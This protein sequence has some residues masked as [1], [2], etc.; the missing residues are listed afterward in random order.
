VQASFDSCRRALAD[1]APVPG[2]RATLEHRRRPARTERQQRSVA[3]ACLF[4]EKVI[5]AE[6]SYSTYVTKNFSPRAYL[7]GARHF[8]HDIEGRLATLYT[9]VDH[10]PL[11]YVITLNKAEKII[12]RKTHD[13]FRFHLSQ[14]FILYTATS[15]KFRANTQTSFPTIYRHLKSL[16]QQRRYRTYDS[17]QW[18][19]TKVTIRSFSVL[20]FIADKTSSLSLQAR[21]SPNGACCDRGLLHW[22]RARVRI[23]GQRCPT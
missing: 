22:Q 12:D 16:R 14:L 13:K 8:V 19:S 4:L 15:N 17:G 20:S 6:Q 1:T 11:N 2:R 9:N 5:S 7:Q 21:T 3:A 18:A 23:G 10:K